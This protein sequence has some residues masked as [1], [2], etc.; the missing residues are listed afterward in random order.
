MYM[1]LQIKD[2]FE[3]QKKKY[4]DFKGLT[5]CTNP[6]IAVVKVR[7]QAAE[8]FPQFHLNGMEKNIGIEVTFGF[9]DVV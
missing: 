4:H 3:N 1:Y 2:C 5:S 8:M 6:C 7:W 9:C